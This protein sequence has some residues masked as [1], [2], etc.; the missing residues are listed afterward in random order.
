M[1]SVRTARSRLLGES[2]DRTGVAVIAT[3]IALAGLGWIVTGKRMAGMDAGPGSDPGAFGFFLAIWVVMMAAMMFPSAWPMVAVYARL[4]LR[5]RQLG[6]PAPAGGTALFVAGYLLTWTGFGLLMWVI[7]QA[8]ARLTGDALAWNH[9]GRW[10][11]GGAVLVA[12]VYEL[13][14]AKY[15][16]LRRCR[17]PFSFLLGA[18]R[19]GAA[20]A[21]RMG[22]EHGA[23]CVGCCWALMVAL[24]TIGVMSVTWMAF[25]AALIAAEKLLPWRRAIVGAVTLLLVALALGVTLVPERV[26]GLTVPG[27]S[28][29]G[30]TDHGSMS[31]SGMR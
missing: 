19:D 7:Y 22:V 25:I 26:P 15:A 31:E 28:E 6:R 2:V 3:L 11:A 13:T 23:W 21:L 18:W 14:P 29:G 9:A 12:A 16:C 8:A 30:T 20:G 27:S 5:R 17:G 10:L 24:F 4:Q 1:R